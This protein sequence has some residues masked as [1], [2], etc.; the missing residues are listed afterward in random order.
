M[1]QHRRGCTV[2][3]FFVFD[4]APIFYAETLANLEKAVR[5]E[6]TPKDE[7]GIIA[8]KTPQ[9]HARPN[10]LTLIGKIKGL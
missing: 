6:R 9:Q 1:P 2:R 8:D 10:G 4:V 7:V 3:H 5:V